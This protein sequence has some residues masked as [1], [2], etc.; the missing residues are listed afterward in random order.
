MTSRKTGEEADSAPYV[1]FSFTHVLPPQAISSLEGEVSK[2]NGELERVKQKAAD[3]DKLEAQIER[4]AH[5]EST[6]SEGTHGRLR[7]A[8]A[9]RKE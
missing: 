1:L 5:H 4:M 3:V 7:S 9:R 6:Y 8:V 2:L